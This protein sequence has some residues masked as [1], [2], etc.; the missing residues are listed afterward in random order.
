MPDAPNE[1]TKQNIGSDP[2]GEKI[3]NSQL[4]NVIVTL[5]NHTKEKYQ[6]P[7]KTILELVI[8]EDLFNWP[9]K[10]YIIYNNRYEAIERNMNPNAWFFRMDARDE[11]SIQIKTISDEPMNITY[12]PEVWEM[13]LNFVIYDTEDIPSANIA[14]KMKKIYFWDKRYQMMMDKKIY[15]STVTAQKLKNASHL[16]DDERSM[17]TGDAIKNLISDPKAGGYEDAIDEENWDNGITKQFYTSPVQNNIADDIK[18][19]VTNHLSEKDDD[20]T[21]L[22]YNNRVDNKFQL[23]PMHKFFDKAGSGAESPGDWQLEHYFFEDIESEEGST[24]PYRAPYRE[25]LSFEV[26]IKIGEWSKITTYEFSDMSGIDNTKA[27]VSKPVYSYCLKTGSFKVDY[28]DNEIEKVKSEFKRIYTDKLLPAGK[29]EPIFTLNKTKK[30][31]INIEPEFTFAKTAY[32]DNIQNRLIQGRGKILFGGVFLN[33]FIKFR[34]TGSPHRTV[35]KFIGIDRK[36]SDTKLN[37]D[38]KICG[39]WFVT[40]V[41]HVWNHNRYV[42]DICA[43]KVHMY[44]GNDV[45]EGVE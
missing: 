25:D 28:A 36:T 32:A 30:D 20:V 3:S 34:V 15:W 42:N 23:V 31:Q 26:D 41:K 2:N 24:S 27:L 39:Q 33:E 38:N 19:F 1:N 29:A 37:F 6:L 35:G 8:E 17:L 44:K 13:D 7:T 14:T 5:D 4:F 10:G 9:Y 45:D 12:P 22:K 18:Y 21:L 43:V 11:I 16:T 40:D